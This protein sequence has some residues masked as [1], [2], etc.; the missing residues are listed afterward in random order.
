M[1]LSKC[2]FV[3]PFCRKTRITFA[4]ANKLELRKSGAHIQEIFPPEYFDA[5]YREIL[6]S[7]ICSNCQLSVFRDPEDEEE[8]E[9]V[10]FDAED[11][12]KEVNE[13]ENRIRE[14]YENAE[15]D[16]NISY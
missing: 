8:P 10:L 16:D 13:V 2:E 15:A 7:N 3:C 9:L 14:M 1:K 6:I 5:T 4:D 12:T 11:G